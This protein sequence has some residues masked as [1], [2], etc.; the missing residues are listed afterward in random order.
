MSLAQPG[1]YDPFAPVAPVWREFAFLDLCGF[2]H[3]TETHGAQAA[4]EELRLFRAVTREVC[5]RREVRVGK[6]LGDGVLL[7][8]TTPA[9]A[10]AAAVEL[11]ERWRPL[12][13]DLRAGVASGTALLFD[14]DDYAG[15]PLNVAAR[16]CQAADPA[17]TL[18]AVDPPPAA[19]VALPEWVRVTGSRTLSLAGV[20][21]TD[22]WVLHL[23]DDVD[24]GPPPSTPGLIPHL[25]AGDRPG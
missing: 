24:L 5:G 25:R 21:P 12:T 7:V 13:L 3:F 4:I 1:P 19:A 17:E 22:A 16:L 23:A 9:T 8:A 18:L 10:V 20:G 15:R 11:V 14:G 2:T 6:W